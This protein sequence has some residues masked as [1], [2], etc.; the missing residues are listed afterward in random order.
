[1]RSP[2]HNRPILAGIA[3]VTLSVIGLTGCGTPGAPQPPSLKLPEPVNDLTA[4]RAGNSVTLG[5]T[6]PRKTTDHVPLKGPIPAAICWREGSGPCLPMAQTSQAPE[7][8]AELQANLPPALLTGNPR[9]ISLFVELKSPKGRTAGLSNPARVLAGSA[10][11]AVT[12]LTAQVRADGVALHWAGNETTPVRLHRT[13]ITPAPRPA[14]K[15]VHGAKPAAEPPLR[16][17]LVDPPASGQA[18][19]ALDRT[20]RFSEVYEYTAQRVVQFQIDGT[21]RE[22]AGETSAPVR[23][24][25]VDTFPPAV[26]QGLAAVY[27]SEAKTIDLSWEPDTEE[28]LAGYIVYRAGPDGDWKRISGPQPIPGASYRDPAPEP[29]HDYRYAVS[30]IDQ[31]GHES[32][33]SA[34][35]A[36][37][38]PNL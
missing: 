12:G 17:L 31:L 32:N 26:P 28:D 10:P 4:V 19:G 3:M 23:V 33:R 9:P 29:G 16:D 24:A 21:T 15:A 13:L 1:M 8:K 6:M 18:Q 22:L 11:G 36:E 25:T 37:S 14:A 7:A 35:A 2:Q 20:A 34:E 30:A 5:W 27:V 38:V